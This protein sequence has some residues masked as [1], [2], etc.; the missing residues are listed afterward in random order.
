M[1]Y[2]SSGG[3][4]K[5]IPKPITNVTQNVH[6]EQAKTDMSS[7]EGFLEDLKG[8]MKD[9]TL[10]EDNCKVFSHKVLVIDEDNPKALIEYWAWKGNA[11]GKPCGYA[12]AGIDP[13]E[14]PNKLI[15]N[16]D[17]KNN[18]DMPKG[19][20]QQGNGYY[21]PPPCIC[22]TLDYNAPVGG[23]NVIKTPAEILADLLEKTGITPPAGMQAALLSTTVGG[24]EKG[25]SITDYNTQ[26]EAITTVNQGLSVTCNGKV[27][28]V[29][30]NG[31]VT[32][33]TDAQDANCDG[34]ADSFLPKDFQVE[35]Q[36]GSA[37]RLYACLT[38]TPD[39]TA[40]EGAIE[41]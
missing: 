32:Y 14:E 4:A 27:S 7:I 33:G 10:A 8:L 37:T 18:F 29:N 34:V 21:N 17:F 41:Q 22:Q 25:T 36:E 13:N 20:F 30:P 6:V 15:N 11:T 35:I 2:M 28:T 5:G 23:G 19:G 38:W 16:E 24:F 3:K 9:N 31:Q 39:T 40:R 12:L 26:V 1:S